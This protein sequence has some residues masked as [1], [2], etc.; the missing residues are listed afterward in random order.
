MLLTAV[1]S[2][3]GYCPV[4]RETTVLFVLLESLVGSAELF[5]L[6][7]NDVPIST[8]PV[9]HEGWME[10]SCCVYIFRIVVNF[11]FRSF[12]SSPKFIGLNQFFWNQI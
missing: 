5:Y 8:I 2:W 12:Q 6:P 10:S 1:R 4:E 11:F 9:L 7:A 3:N